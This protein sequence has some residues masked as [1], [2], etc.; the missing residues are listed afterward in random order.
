MVA[1]VVGADEDRQVAGHVAA[2]DRVDAD[3]LQRFGEAHDV[4]R[5]VEPAAVPSPRVHAKIEAIG[6]VEVSL[7]C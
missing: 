7:P 3:P 6:L 4:R 5:V 2:L 1:R